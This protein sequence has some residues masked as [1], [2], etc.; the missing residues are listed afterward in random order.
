MRIV[1]RRSLSLVLVLLI[2][3]CAC[4]FYIHEYY[5]STTSEDDI[6]E[7]LAKKREFCDRIGWITVTVYMSSEEC[8]DPIIPGFSWSFDYVECFAYVVVCNESSP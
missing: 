2:A 5:Q 3:A 6:D 4:V 8:K 7:Y 1:S